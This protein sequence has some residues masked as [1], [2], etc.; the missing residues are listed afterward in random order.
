MCCQATPQGYESPHEDSESITERAESADG[1]HINSVRHVEKIGKRISNPSLMKLVKCNE[2]QFRKYF[3]Y[4]QS[5]SSRKYKP[6][7]KKILSY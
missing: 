5:E 1:T 6:R 7:L 2:M 3:V 4:N